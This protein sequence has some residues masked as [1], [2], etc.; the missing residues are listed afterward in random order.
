[1]NEEVCAFTT[2]D[3][4]QYVGFSPKKGG[5]FYLALR[6][7]HPMPGYEEWECWDPV[8]RG[9]TRL[10]GYELRLVHSWYQRIPNEPG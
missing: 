8:I 3:L 1:V 5:R 9:Y 7:R 2:G 6:V 10:W 4:L